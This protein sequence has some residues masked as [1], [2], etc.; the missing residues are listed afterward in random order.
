MLSSLIPQSRSQDRVLPTSEKGASGRNCNCGNCIQYRRM[1]STVCL[2]LFY[3]LS[4]LCYSVVSPYMVTPVAAFGSNH[5][6]IARDRSNR[7]MPAVGGA[8]YGPYF[9]IC[10]CCMVRI[11]SCGDNR[12]KPDQKLQRFPLPYS[13]YANGCD[14]VYYH[15]SC[16]TVQVAEYKR[17]G[18]CDC[19]ILWYF[20]TDHRPPPVIMDPHWSSSCDGLKRKW[21]R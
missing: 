3:W 16:A 7:A 9:P 14:P 17:A 13:G 5:Q 2:P 1:G 8:Y 19:D 15:A 21:T 6:I 20:Q 11:R 4:S 10:H 12:S 18:W